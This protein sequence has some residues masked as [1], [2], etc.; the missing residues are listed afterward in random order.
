MANSLI[1]V[2]KTQ[3]FSPSDSEIR[4]AAMLNDLLGEVRILS[5]TLSSIIGSGL[6]GASAT[7]VTEQA[8]GQAPT[9]GA[10]TA[11]S[12]GD[13]THGTPPFDIPDG[14]VTDAMVDDTVV[15]VGDFKE[16]QDLT[17]E[18]FFLLRDLE[19]IELGQAPESG[20][21]G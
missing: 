5:T 13:H 19:L 9:P 17:A 12:R 4:R 3:H 10:V 1:K 21:V 15:T 6:A 14:F 20:L 11:Y 18:L 2:T 7:V 8:F 16:M